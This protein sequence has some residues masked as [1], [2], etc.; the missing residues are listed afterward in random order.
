ML[1]RA[2]TADQRTRIFDGLQQRN[3]LVSILR[4]G[5]PLLG[6]LVLIGL[7][8]QI[9]IASLLD[10]FGISN[11]SIDRGNLVVDTPSYSGMSANGTMYTISAAGARAALGSIDVVALDGA[12]LTMANEGGSSVTAKAAEAMLQTTDQLVSVDGITEVSLSNGSAGTVKGLRADMSREIMVSDG[13]A[14]FRF[15]TGATLKAEF[16]SYD[17]KKQIWVFHG[18]TLDLPATPGEAFPVAVTPGTTTP[19]TVAP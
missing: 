3:R 7:V 19:G 8:A 10:Q 16:M 11:V 12:V 18:A 14:N 9:V 6:V 5:L 4:I 15:N 13:A 2:E 1:A 17:A